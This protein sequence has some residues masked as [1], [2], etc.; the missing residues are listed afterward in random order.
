MYFDA[1]NLKATISGIEY[2]WSGGFGAVLKSYERG[3]KKNEVRMIGRI[4]FFAFNV[5]SSGIRREVSWCPQEKI[6]AEWLRNLKSAI[7]AA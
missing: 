4:V 1:E 5:S 7:F 2:T 6:D 3:V